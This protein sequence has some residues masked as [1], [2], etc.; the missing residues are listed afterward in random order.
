MIFRRVKVPYWILPLHMDFKSHSSFCRAFK[1]QHGI[2]PTE[3]KS[4]A[5]V[6]NN[7]LPIN[8]SNIRIVGG[9]KNHGR[10]EKG[11]KFP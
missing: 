2:T 7:Y 11:N 10:Y 3:A 1:E 9:R 5:A 8:F 4:P 6:F